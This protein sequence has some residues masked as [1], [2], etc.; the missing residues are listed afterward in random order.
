MEREDKRQLH[1]ELA[2][3]L[4]NNERIMAIIRKNIKAET[5]HEKAI[6]T[7]EIIYGA[8]KAAHTSILDDLKILC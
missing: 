7:S 6:I 2:K 3:M 8:V 5:E 1:L 4:A